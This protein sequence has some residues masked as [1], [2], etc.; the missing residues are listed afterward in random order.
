MT[1]QQRNASGNEAANADSRF[2]TV[3]YMPGIVQAGSV[4]EAAL[5]LIRPDLRAIKGGSAVAINLE[6][7][8]HLDDETTE[9][10]IGRLLQRRLIAQAA[11]EARAGMLAVVLYLPNGESNPALSLMNHILGFM[12][13][14]PVVWVEV[15][16]LAG[17][18][19]GEIGRI[20][21]RTPQGCLLASQTEQ[22]LLDVIN[23]YLQSGS[24]PVPH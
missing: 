20:D 6:P 10:F 3:R 9:R 7:L 1:T 13:E 8:R 17:L 23:R 19:Q 4:S 14:Q 11:F 22:L 21:D 15:G 18:H 2:T 16:H 12:K 24:R 5:Y